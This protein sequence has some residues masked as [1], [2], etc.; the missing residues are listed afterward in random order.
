MGLSWVGSIYSRFSIDP[1][2]KKPLHHQFK[3][4]SI[5]WKDQSDLKFFNC[6]LFMSWSNPCWSIMAARPTSMLIIAVILHTPIHSIHVHIFLITIFLIR[7]ESGMYLCRPSIEWIH[8]LL[9][10]S[11]QQIFCHFW[12]DS[13]LKPLFFV[14]TFNKAVL[15][16]SSKGVCSIQPKVFIHTLIFNFFPSNLLVLTFLLRRVVDIHVGKDNM[17]QCLLRYRCVIGKSTELQSGSLCL[18]FKKEVLKKRFFFIPF[19]MHVNNLLAVW[20]VYLTVV[21]PYSPI[22]MAVPIWY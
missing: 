16:W 22:T 13:F 7:L 10:S 15:V 14:D 18:C 6:H 5:S 19:L 2:S 8:L 21:K 4:V 11:M 12:G 3:N 17:W 9:F 1:D 20:L